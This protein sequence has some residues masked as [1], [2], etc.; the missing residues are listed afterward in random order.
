MPCVLSCIS[1]N[2]Y[3][4][5]SH[6]IKDGVL[7]VNACQIIIHPRAISI[8]NLNIGRCNQDITRVQVYNG[9]F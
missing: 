3:S 1:F 2:N 6:I 7:Q 9:Y 5:V 4:I 8:T